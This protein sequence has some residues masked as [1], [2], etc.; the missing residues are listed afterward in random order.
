MAP[1]ANESLIVPEKPLK[2]TK[3]P[4]KLSSVETAPVAC[5]LLIAPL[6]DPTRPPAIA[7]VPPLT[8]PVAKEVPIV[9]LASLKP[10]RPP[11]PTPWNI[12]PLP[13]LIAPPACESGSSRN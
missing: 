8:A 10:T 7:K 5:E 1:D 4:A 9:P 6:F 13:P 2:P 11:S 3:P 12:W